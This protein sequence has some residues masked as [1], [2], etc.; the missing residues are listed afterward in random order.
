MVFAGAIYY[1]DNIHSNFYL[2]KNYSFFLLTPSMYY[3]ARNTAYYSDIMF[4]L[5]KNGHIGNLEI[6]NKLDIIPS[7]V[8]NKDI[9]LIGGEGTKLD[10]YI[11]S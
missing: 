6:S 1:Q 11:I 10:A 9:K 8:L 4:I 3:D 5:H 2:F 7:I